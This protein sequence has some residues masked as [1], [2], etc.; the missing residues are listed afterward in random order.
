MLLYLFYMEFHQILREFYT[1]VPINQM[2][3]LKAFGSILVA[4]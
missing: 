1:H 2:L 3:Q 4:S